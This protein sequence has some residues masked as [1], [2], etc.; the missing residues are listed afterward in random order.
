MEVEGFGPKHSEKRHESD[1]SSV[2]YSR[3][4]LTILIN[5]VAKSGERTVLKVRFN[6]ARGFRYLDE[7]DLQYYWETQL[8]T[9]PQHVFKILSGGWSNGEALQP[10]VLTVTTALETDEWFIVTTNGC[11]TV[12]SGAE[13]TAEYVNA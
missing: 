9:V 1:I 10:A 6:W 5:T 4:G 8:F 13:P 3:A 11:I 7:G 2:V 12:L